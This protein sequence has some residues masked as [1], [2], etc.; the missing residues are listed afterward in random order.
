M[1]YSH[2]HRGK[3]PP[4]PTSH[5]GAPRRRRHTDSHDDHHTPTSLLL[6]KRRDARANAYVVYS[7]RARAIRAGVIFS[8]AMH[9]RRYT[10]RETES[11]R[12]LAPKR[13]R[14]RAASRGKKHLA[15]GS[16][17]IFNARSPRPSLSLFLTVPFSRARR[18]P[19]I[20]KPDPTTQYHQFAC[21]RSIANGN[22]RMTFISVIFLLFFTNPNQ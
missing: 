21:N 22:V 20:D 5:E 18:V 7:E 9:G 12:C 3:A 13:R 8:S 15:H 6:E 10:R 11:R 17:A 4:S 14:A 1:R 16:A 19:E 2:H